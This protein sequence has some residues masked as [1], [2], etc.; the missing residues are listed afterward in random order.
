VEG[1]AGEIVGVAGVEGSGVHELLRLLGG[2]LA[3]AFGSVTLPRLIGFIPEDRLRDALIDEFTLSENLALRDAGHR[4]GRLN[5][6]GFVERTAGIMQRHDVRAPS[7]AA[8]ADSL[9]GGNQ[10]KFVVGRELDEHPA[11]VVAENPV[12]GLDLRATSH[13][14]EELAAAANAGS[15]VVVYSTDVDELLPLAD[16]MLVVFAGTVR[17]VPVERNAVAAALVGAP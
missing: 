9:S 12:R 15:A 13:V 7:P 8:R 3:P 17:E 10:Q 1:F 4:T 2:R 14:L 11:L 6:P 5:W 16:R